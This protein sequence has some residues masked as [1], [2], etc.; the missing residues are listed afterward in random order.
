M[1]DNFLRAL[2]Y[3]QYG[4][5]QI[6]LPNGRQHQFTGTQPGPQAVLQLHDKRVIRN[7]AWRGDIGFAEDY[8]QG[9]WDSPDIAALIEFSLRNE[10]AL[11]G[12]LYGNRWLQSLMTLRYWLQRNNRRGSR[13]NIQAHYDLSNAFYALWLDAGMTYSSALY[14]DQNVSLAEAQD[15][16]YDRILQQLGNRP[17]RILEIGCGWGGFAA[18][19][20]QS[21]TEYLTGITLSSEQH[22]YARQRLDSTAADIQLTD[23]RDL[24]GNYDNIVS[25][26]MFE[27]VGEGYWRTY[28]DKIKHLLSQ[29]GRAVIQTITIRDEHFAAYRRS[30]DSIRSYIFPGGM[31]PSPNRFRQVAE[32][33]GLTLADSHTFGQDYARTLR[34]WQQ[35]FDAQTEAIRALAFDTAFIRLWRYYLGFCAGAFAAGR[36]NVMQVTLTHA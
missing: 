36:T 7:L 9:R 34:C 12:Y 20:L 28:F 1:T 13:H 18:R 5:L 3:V 2:Q 11:A 35:R 6:T 31:L 4:S 16:K 23:Y 22:Q 10:Q 21:G 14:P 25:I 15:H 24:H 32:Q 19:A 17:Q 30:G 27:A 26:E 8:R 29:Q 33:A